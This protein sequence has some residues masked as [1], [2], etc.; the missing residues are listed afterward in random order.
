[1]KFLNSKHPHVAILEGVALNIFLLTIGLML[2]V[3]NVSA[4]YRFDGEIIGGQGEELLL[5]EQF[6]DQSRI[7]DTIIPDETGRFSFVL[8]STDP[9]GLY[10][11]YFNQNNWLD[12]IL[13]VE[14][15]QF[16]TIQAAPEQNLILFKG[17]QNEILYAYQ[18]MQLNGEVKQ[19]MLEE[20]IMQYP[21]EDKMLK[22]AKKT[23]KKSYLEKQKY[24]QKLNKKHGDTFVARYLSFI[25]LKDWKYY[26]SKQLDM[27]LQ[28]FRQRD[29]NDT[30]LLNSNAY[31]KG[32]IDF[33]MLYGKAGAGQEEQ[34][35]L[36]QRGI[37]TLFTII[38]PRTKVYDFA[39]SY[40]M[41]GF[42]QY[43][44]E[45]VIMHVV[46][47]YADSCTNEMLET[48]GRLKFYRNFYNGVTIENF[49]LEDPDG[50]SAK[51]YD[52]VTGYTVL[53]FWSTECSHCTQMNLA[54]KDIYPQMKEKGVDIV[55]VSLDGNLKALKAY[56]R[57]NQLYWK[58]YA[59]GKGWESPLVEQF[60]LFATPT[61]FL[62]DENFRLIGKPVNLNQLIFMINKL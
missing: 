18:E 36:F 31:S 13:G 14:D 37:D 5:A 54:L 49:T 22:L 10:R 58:V 16:Q 2:F 29:W 3:G 33:L 35:V 17:K 20:F 21:E 12:F 48:S 4:Q 42:E 46:N 61:M 41:E 28:A 27:Q 53:V 55:S 60:D 57:E 1:M 15:V 34:E 30:L 51:F 45:S 11:L 9:T 8:D 50:S 26:S 52:L 40:L 25:Y 47:N 38:P 7:V 62:V 39:I 44:M 19:G 56:L 24:L 6:G 59:D 43:E 23:L 32:I